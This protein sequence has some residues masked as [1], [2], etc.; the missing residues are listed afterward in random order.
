M[1][2]YACLPG[3]S[4]VCI[5]RELGGVDLPAPKTTTSCT[6]CRFLNSIVLASAV[7]K[8]VISSALMRA[9]GAASLSNSC[10][11]PFGVVLCELARDWGCSK[12]EPECADSD[13]EVDF[14]EDVID[15]PSKG[16]FAS[17]ASVTTFNPMPSLLEAGMKSVVW[18]SLRLSVVRIGWYEE[19][20][21][22]ESS[23]VAVE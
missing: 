17:V 3:N 14:R 15:E 6:L 13:R 23:S 1:C 7:R 19:Q 22:L 11:V 12:E 2:Q 4:Q 20:Q 10:N 21:A 18:P 16:F 5:A 9:R 8:A